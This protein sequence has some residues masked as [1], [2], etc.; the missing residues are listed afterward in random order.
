[1]IKGAIFDLDGTLLDSMGVWERVGEEYLRTLGRTPNEG[2]SSALRELTLE[3]AAEYLIDRYE[4]PLS[5]GETV[6]GI[7]RTMEDAYVNGTRLKA[8]AA[9]LLKKM[10]DSGV[11]ICLATASDRELCDRVLERHGIKEY[12]CATVTC[13]ELST[14]KTEP[15]IYRTAL[16]SLGTKKEETLVFEDALHAIVTAKNDGFRAVAVYDSCEPDPE[17]IKKHAD[18][19]ITDFS[20]FDIDNIM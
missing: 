8:G 5:V 19:Y 3:Q 10:R 11:K 7:E 18:V 12:F 20:D 16:S 4:I 15:L 6:D 1:M 14:D 17:E 13:G 9:E 2:L